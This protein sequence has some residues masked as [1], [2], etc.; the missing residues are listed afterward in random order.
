MQASLAMT[1]N[2]CMIRFDPD[3]P[4]DV[5]PTIAPEELESGNPIQR[6]LTLVDE[7]DHG[8]SAGLWDCT[9]QTSVWMDQPSH[10]FMLLL[11]GEVTIVEASRE[12]T[13]RAGDAFVLPQGLRCQWK[14]PGYV[15]KIWVTYEDPALAAS[16][17]NAVD[18]A[19]LVD[20]SGPLEPSAPLPPEILVSAAPT[21]A[22]RDD[23][24]DPTGRFAAGVWATAAYQRRALPFDRWELMHIV[25][26]ETTL[27]DPAGGRE[28]VRA[29][30]TFLVS[31]GEIRS[32][33][34]ERDLRKIFCLFKPDD[35]DA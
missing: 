16:S 14:Q 10:E 7:P 4:L 35:G 9:A 26:G 20:P 24:V 21:Q 1:H 32:W 34:G 25:S 33:E 23:F 13:F 30:D 18:H 29:G 12:S 28:M 3:A 27:T 22:A 19:I 2:A 8:F 17:R 11:A 5:W 15:K 6:G 31:R